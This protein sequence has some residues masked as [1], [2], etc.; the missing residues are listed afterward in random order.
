[1][2]LRHKIWGLLGGRHKQRNDGEGKRPVADSAQIT[3]R[4]YKRR[5]RDAV[6][7][8][9]E[10]SFGGVCIDENIERGFGQ[11]GGSWQEHKRSTVDY[12]LAN[13]PYDT[14]VADVDGKT[15]GFICTRLQRYRLTGHVANLAVTAKY[16]RMG[17]GKALMAAAL[18][19]FRDAG[20]LYARIETLEQNV[21]AQKFYP[22]LG[23][24][25]IARQIYYFMEL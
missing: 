9:A 10:E 6:L 14:F 12:D 20:M 15:V 2:G 19:H 4:Q 13:N 23:F 7:R 22:A 16:Q 3:T 18:D 25:E 17:V 11:I 1:V 21:K 24:K 5:D 8:I